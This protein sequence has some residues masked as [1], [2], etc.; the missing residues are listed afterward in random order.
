MASLLNVDLWTGLVAEDRRQSGAR[1]CAF[2]GEDEAALLD[3]AGRCLPAEQVTW[4]LAR[5]LDSIGGIR[6]VGVEHVRMLTVGD[7]DRLL[8]ALCSATFSPEMDLVARCP[9]EECGELTELTVSLETLTGHVPA[10]PPA[11]SFEKQIEL[12]EGPFTLRFRLPTG[13][14]Q[15]KA[16]RHLAAQDAARVEAELVRE[17]VLELRDAKGR[18]VDC[19]ARRLAQIRPHLEAAWSELDPSADCFSQVECPACGRAYSAVLDALSLFMAGLENRG[20][21][22]HQVDRLAR[23]YHWSERE[24]L[25]LSF[26]RRQRY[27]ELVDSQARPS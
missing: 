21:I 14:D 20:D 1:L 24:L 13:Q 8:F 26:Q 10:T 7:R 4:L 6:P 27:L 23:A 3:T 2:T 15:E 5:L 22:F 16:C 19:A 25:A 17:C 12:E 11:D 18:P 9:F